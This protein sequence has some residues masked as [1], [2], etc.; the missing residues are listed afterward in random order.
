MIKHIISFILFRVWLS[1]IVQSLIMGPIE[2]MIGT[3]Q[4][5]CKR[6]YNDK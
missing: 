1:P 3:Y 2:V 4:Y 6:I 5:C